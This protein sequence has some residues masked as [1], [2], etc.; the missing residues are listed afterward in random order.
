MEL[1]HALDEIEERA[2][3][4]A[5]HWKESDALLQSGTP[6]APVEHAIANVYQQALNAQADAIA[7]MQLSVKIGRALLGLADDVEELELRLPE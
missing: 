4:H 3:E 5:L 2:R 6:T 1:R 7:A